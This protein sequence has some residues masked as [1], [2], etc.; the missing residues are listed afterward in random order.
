MDTVEIR[1]NL[2]AML[3][4]QQMRKAGFCP[5]NLKQALRCRE[6]ANEENRL[7]AIEVFEKRKKNNWTL[8][9]WFV[10]SYDYILLVVQIRSWYTCN[11]PITKIIDTR[12]K[13][14]GCTVR[15]ES[16]QMY[17]WQ[18]IPEEGLLKIQQALDC[19]VKLEDMRVAYPVIRN[20]PRP[21]P[22]IYYKSG[23]EC[24]QIYQW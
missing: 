8:L 24:I 5:V 7:R 3:P 16:L 21:D 6:I 4:G 15:T 17:A 12:V 1:Q 18:D 20:L 23:E 22:I 9:R 13:G 2:R 14:L 10:D 19:G 11:I